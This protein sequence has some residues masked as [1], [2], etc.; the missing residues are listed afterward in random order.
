MDVSSMLLSAK[1][2]KIRMKHI[3]VMKLVI[4]SKDINLTKLQKHQEGLTHE[5]YQSLQ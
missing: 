4:L 3:C 1:L 2:Q 5:I